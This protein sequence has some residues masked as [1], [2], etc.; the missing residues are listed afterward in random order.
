MKIWV[1][2]RNY[3]DKTNKMCGSFELDQAKMLAKSGHDVCYISC[4]FHPVYKVKKWGFCDWQD[5]SVH[6]YA[7]SQ[8]FFP[9]RFR[10]YF[11]KFKTKKWKKLLG[12]V[13]NEQ[14]KPDIVHVHFPTMITNA[15]VLAYLKKKTRLIFATE[16][17][18]NVMLQ[19]L[20]AH[21]LSQLQFYVENADGFISVSQ[22]LS[23]S[24]RK[25][26]G[27]RKKLYVIPNM[28]SSDFNKKPVNHEGFR[29]I[30]VGRLISIK[31]FDKII[32]AFAKAFQG[33]DAITLTIV[34]GGIQFGNLNKVINELGISSQV[35][36][37]GTLDH[38]HTAEKINNSDVLVSFSRSETFGVPIIEGWYCG[39]PVISSNAI[40]FTELWNDSLGYLIPYNDEDALFSSMQQIY[41]NYDSY[42]KE[43]IKRFAKEHF[44]EATISKQLN[45]LYQS[46]DIS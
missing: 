23:E 1:I 17:W 27:T 16:H 7:Y 41:Q 44:S 37:T 5:D 19:K 34:G 40:G 18:S 12:K 21:E 11:D 29:F 24:V 20:N 9:Q 45:D 10:F 32:R 26:T 13:E 36:L 30:S 28:V 33:K 22:P 38:Q 4:V 42:N 6:V 15:D 8:I 3:P 2:G 39:L 35:V 31:Q 43:E 25:L 14:G 46:F